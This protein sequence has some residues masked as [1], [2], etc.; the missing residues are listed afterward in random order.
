MIYSK[1]MKVCVALSVVAFLASSVLFATTAV[2]DKN[3]AIIDNIMKI[4]IRIQKY[5][6]PVA[7]VILLYAL[8][9]YYVVGSEAFEYK[10]NGQKMIMGISIFMAVIQCLPLLYAFVTI[11]L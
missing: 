3:D 6:W 1:L 4:L 8:Y 10:V 11:G 2:T 7:L 9:Q 5:S